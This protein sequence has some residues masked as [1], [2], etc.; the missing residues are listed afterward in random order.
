MVVSGKDYYVEMQSI[1]K[2]FSGN[3]AVDHVNFFV[4]KGEIQCLVG[5]NGA[6]K[7]T[8]IKILSGIIQADEGKISIENIFNKIR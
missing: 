5:E 4:N 8:L 6:G 1:V 3:I 2:R 7:S